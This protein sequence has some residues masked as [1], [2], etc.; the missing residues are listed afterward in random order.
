VYR[1][2]AILAIGSVIDC[3][4]L[5]ISAARQRQIDVKAE[6]LRVGKGYLQENAFSAFLFLCAIRDH[7]F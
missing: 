2:S 4:S 6:V 7:E 5:H 3:L 1:F